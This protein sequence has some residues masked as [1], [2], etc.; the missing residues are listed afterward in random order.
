[1]NIIQIFPGKIWG[2]AEQ[3][4][5]DLGTALCEQGH[6]VSYLSH[7]VDTIKN[8]TKG[9]IPL[10]T[11]PFKGI[12]DFKTITALSDIIK[13]KKADIIHIHDVKFVP[14]V[15]AAKALSKCDVKIILHRHIA[16]GSRTNPL[17]RFW[18]KKLHNMLFVSNLARNLWQGANKWMPQDKCK[19]V[20]NSIPPAKTNAGQTANPSVEKPAKEQSLREIYNVPND[21]PLLIFTGR[22]RKSKGCAVIIDALA[23]I[24]DLPFHM[25]FIGSCKPKD[26]I[27]TLRAK[28]AVAGIDS[29]VSFHG[30]ANNTRELIKE[31]DIGI[32]PS[33]VREAC[34]LSPM[35]F[36]QAGKPVIA[37]N[38]GAQSEYI[39]NN[40]TGI[41]ISPDNSNEL[42]DSL[43]V[44]INDI[45]FRN[46]IGKSAQE[47]FNMEL[48]YSKFINK[49]IESYK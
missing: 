29:K 26:Y 48:D 30:F 31:A 17:F 25:L 20:I 34:P 27:N 40:K 10:Q 45:E 36:M 12:F 37:T 19:V 47:Y 8:R 6:N 33:I 16:R 21:T 49:I 24:K 41:I 23:A 13:E 32:A 5:L 44:L 2:G 22:V 35:E 28:A 9:I 43:R 1:M 38:N 4:I 42:A 3:F 14:M 46:G 18:F 11:L 7:N 39:Q 15:S